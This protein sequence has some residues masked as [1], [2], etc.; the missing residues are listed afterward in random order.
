MLS[1]STAF[2][3]F[4]FI[5]PTFAAL[6]S[7]E[8]TSP[9]T[10]IYSEASTK[11]YEGILW[12]FE[13][14]N[15]DIFDWTLRVAEDYSLD[16]W[17]ASRGS[18]DIYT[19][20]DSPIPHALLSIPHTTSELSTA[21]RIPSRD[22]YEN[23]IDRWNLTSLEN[24]T[25]HAAY[26]PSWEIDEFMHTLAELYPDEVT[27]L[28]LGHTAM[29]R[30]IYGMQIS[31]STKS[32]SKAKPGF[33][34]TGAQH[35][36][37]WVAISTALY[38]SH[39]LVSNSSESQSMRELLDDFDFYV[40][41]SPNPDGYDHTWETDRFWYKNRQVVDP[42]SP[43]VGIDTNRCGYKWKPHS[44]LGNLGKGKRKKKPVPDDPCSTW[45]P[46]HRA[47]EAPEVNNLAN[48]VSTLNGAGGPHA[49][50]KAFVDLRSYGQMLSTP[51]SFSCKRLP[52]D[53]EDQLEAALGSV[54]ALRVKHGTVFKTGNLCSTLYRAPGNIVDWMYARAGIKYSYAAFLRDTGTYGFSLPAEWIRPV[55]EETGKMIE[56]LAK[57][58]AKQQK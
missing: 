32:S 45:Y 37:E 44:A 46:G 35:A 26:H 24:T 51:Y 56:Y 50:I 40:V 13:A 36:R 17:R 43:C 29:G 20:K 49:K 47:F 18:V 28:R 30:E 9:Q 25:Y 1:F 8:E 57:F 33:L 48:F 15:Q 38:I 39:A 12:Q 27:V 53:A 52:K 41:P 4:T 34:I 10:P 2:Q 23:A 11:I 3:L 54:Q 16:I 58:I 21:V 31:R 55:G 5:I 14:G 42:V 6:W 19:P 22:L 7:Y